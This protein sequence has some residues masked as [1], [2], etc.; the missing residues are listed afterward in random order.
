MR[1]EFSPTDQ[2]F[3]MPNRRPLKL[4][5]LK[6]HMGGIPRGTLDNGDGTG[7]ID[8]NDDGAD[9]GTYPNMVSGDAVEWADEQEGHFPRSTKKADRIK[10]SSRTSG[11]I[12]ERISRKF[13]AYPHWG[14]WRE[15]QTWFSMYQKQRA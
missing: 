2:T 13:P 8:R 12:D 10:E 7:Q 5:P 9:K 6:D 11:R 14:E 15:M 3:T 4:T 1:T